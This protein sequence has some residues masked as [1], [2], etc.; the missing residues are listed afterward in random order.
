MRKH[1]FPTGE[2]LYVAAGRP[3]PVRAVK[4]TGC[5]F[6]DL[7]LEPIKLRRQWVHHRPGRL[8]VCPVRNLKPGS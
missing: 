6:C 5:V 4:S 2:D 1:A 7:N 8:I 3:G